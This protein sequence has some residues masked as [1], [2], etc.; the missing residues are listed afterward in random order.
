[1][2]A[3]S[4]QY[5]ES[6]TQQLRGLSHQIITLKIF[7]VQAER[8]AEVSA[9]PQDAL[10]DISRLTKDEEVQSNTYATLEPYRFVLDG[11]QQPIP[12]SAGDYENYGFV[13]SELSGADG[14]WENAPTIE[15][16]FAENFNFSGLTF[17]F[18][19]AT[20]DYVSELKVSWYELEGKLIREDVLKPDD[21]LFSYDNGVMGAGRIVIKC[22]SS[23]QPY[24]RARITKLWLGLIKEF[25]DTVIASSARNDESDP[26]ARRL[27]TESFNFTIWDLEREYDPDNPKGYW[28]YVNQLQPVVCRMGYSLPDGKVEWLPEERFVL[29]GNP[30][31]R[32]WQNTFSANK[33]LYSLSGTYNK[34]VYSPEPVTFYELA[35]RVLIDALGN[36]PSNWS[37]PEILREY[38]TTAPLPVTTHKECLQLIAQAATCR[39]YTDSKGVITMQQGWYPSGVNNVNV[40]FSSQMSRPAIEVVP[41][42]KDVDV[43][44]YSYAP[45]DEVSEVFNEKITVSGI[46]RLWFDYSLS[47]DTT[48][49]IESGTLL[50][51][52]MYG[53]GCYLTIQGNGEVTVTI[54]GKNVNQATISKPYIANPYISGETDRVENQMITDSKNQA[55]LAVYRARYLQLRTAYTLT[56]RGNPEIEC[57][58]GIYFQSDFNKNLVGV[59]VKSKLDYN[60]AIKGQLIVKR[61]DSYDSKY[62]T[63]EF[64]AGEIMGVI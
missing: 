18:D 11:T 12:D 38:S 63:N 59:V 40:N 3:V 10:S 50:D 26:L 22:I 17:H 1:M 64:Y 58:D 5:A 2:L 46:Q 7:N 23:S 16:T 20:G 39:L 48:A 24:R 15:M 14:V 55:Q 57:G 19:M 56:Y 47:T 62:Y 36:E 54:T 43:L 51:S 25:K 45:A 34:G 6:M 8:S 44:L 28:A 33:L 13:S 41:P 29:D 61:I 37:L 49:V 30:S 42:L 31:K 60:G 4:T 32:E 52:E 21:S 9:T 53:Y 35:E 27:P